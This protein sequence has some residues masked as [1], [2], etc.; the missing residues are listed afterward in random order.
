MRL[1]FIILAFISLSA[2]GQ[3][4]NASAPYRVRA[5]AGCSYL[6]DQYSGAS[7]AY[8]LRLLDCQYA[9]SAIR[10]RRNSDNTE[11]DI[12]FVNGNLDTATLKT[13]VGTGGTDDGFVV[14][15][16]DQTGSRDAVQATSGNQPRIMDNGATI[17][18]DGEIAIV[19]TGSQYLY[20]SNTGITTLAT[21]SE[22]IVFKQYNSVSSAGILV[23]TPATGNDYDR[24]DAVELE[25]AGAAQNFQVAGGAGTAY[26]IAAAGS[27]TLF[28]LV[29][30]IIDGGSGEAW[31]N[32]T[33][34]GTDTYG[35]F[36]TPGG[37][38]LIGA[39]Y[40]GGAVNLTYS[41]QAYYHEMIIYNSAQSA[42]RTGIQT[43]INTYWQVY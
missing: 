3:I 30:H 40:I 29:A 2:E 23:F 13:F 8:S 16:Y 14:T 12:G 43:N 6:L 33:S 21:H 34:V 18:N 36:T 9:G 11:S 15:W 10:V 25:T 24:N 27:E 5:A 42:N 39:R 22:F 37:Y 19:F 28:Q 20:T 26:V 31:Q 32:G 1:L 38:L 17:R 35:S 4:L 7:A 41:I